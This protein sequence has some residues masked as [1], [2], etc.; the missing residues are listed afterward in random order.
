MTIDDIIKDKP[1]GS[2]FYISC[3]AC[4]DFELILTKSEETA[5]R[6]INNNNNDLSYTLTSIIEFRNVN[7]MYFNLIDWLIPN[8]ELVAVKQS[9]CNCS[10]Q[11]LMGIGCNCG[12][13]ERW[14]QL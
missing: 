8:E 1:I 14:R 3:D 11:V 5:W 9:S 7:Y 13:I 4:P 2:I 12:A 6:Y 10:I